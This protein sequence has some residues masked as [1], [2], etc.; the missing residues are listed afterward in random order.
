MGRA[1]AGKIHSAPRQDYEL[2]TSQSLVD[3]EWA[4]LRH[5]SGRSGHRAK[6]GVPAEKGAAVLYAVFLQ[7]A[8]ENPPQERLSHAEYRKQFAPGHHDRPG[9]LLGH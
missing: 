1:A 2:Q 5:H 3:A 7:V 9:L 4:Q 6:L 8:R